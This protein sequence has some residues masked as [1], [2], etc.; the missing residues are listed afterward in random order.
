MMAAS[1]ATS[2][3]PL[4]TSPCSSRYMGCGAAMSCAISPSTRFCAPVGLNG[5][6]CLMRS[7]T[8]S[9]RANAMPGYRRALARFSSSPHS[10]QKNS[11]KI[12]RYCAGERKAFSSR[13]SESG[14]GKCS[15]RIARPAVR[16]FQLLEDVRG[17][18][19]VTSARWF[20]ESD[21]CRT[22]KMRVVTLPAAS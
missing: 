5:S 11:S 6:I 1:A 19:V 8:R 20:P 4:P 13:R 14:G 15:A 17:Q 7:R 12:S 9:V 3:L 21:A 2:V 22:R 18:R 16:Q 10:S